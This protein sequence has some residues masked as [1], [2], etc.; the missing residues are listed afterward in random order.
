ME[1][2]T[3][4]ECLDPSA[5]KTFFYIILIPKYVEMSF[6]GDNLKKHVCLFMASEIRTS[7]AIDAFMLLMEGRHV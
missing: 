6:K 1:Y 5:M 4:D 2:N 7:S 3:R